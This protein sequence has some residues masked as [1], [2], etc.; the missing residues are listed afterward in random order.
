MPE[1]VPRVWTAPSKTQ[2]QSPSHGAEGRWGS[3]GQSRQPALTPGV[4]ATQTTFPQTLASGLPLGT[5]SGGQGTSSEQLGLRVLSQA[6]RVGRVLRWPGSAVKTGRV[7]SEP[8]GRGE[9]L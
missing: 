7:Y 6:R 9:T 2:E 5:L 3:T 8:G 1:G 4:T